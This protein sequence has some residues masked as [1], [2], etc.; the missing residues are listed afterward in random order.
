[1]PVIVVYIFDR[2]RPAY[3]WKTLFGSKNKHVERMMIMQ[4]RTKEANIEKFLVHIDSWC[5]PLICAIYAK[6]KPA[7]KLSSLRTLYNVSF[8]AALR[9]S[10][11]HTSQPQPIEVSPRSRRV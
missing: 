6:L 11:G 3:Y 1:M 5:D 10:F 8:T 7:K 4:K 2:K 9:V